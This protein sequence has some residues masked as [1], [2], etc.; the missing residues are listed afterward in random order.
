LADH[1]L[2]KKVRYVLLRPLRPELDGKDVEASSRV[3]EQAIGEWRC[4]SEIFVF[5]PH[6]WVS[7]Y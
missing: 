3:D 4:K 2:F 7:F 1:A 6:I 5:S